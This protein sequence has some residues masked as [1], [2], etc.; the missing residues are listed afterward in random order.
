LD[1]DFVFC[2]HTDLQKMRQILVE[3]DFDILCGCTRQ[4]AQNT[5]T[6]P[7][8]IILKNK[9]IRLKSVNFKNKEF[10]E[11]DFGTNFFIAK[12]D[13][14]KMMGGWD[15]RLKLHTEHLDFF[16]TAQLCKL[17][18]G[19]CHIWIDHIKRNDSMAYKVHRAAGN[20]K[21]RR[22]LKNKWEIKD[23]TKPPRG[24]KIIQH[25]HGRI[26]NE[27]LVKLKK[28]F[29]KI[30][31]IEIDP[32]S[33][34]TRQCWF[35]APGIPKHRRENKICVRRS[36]HRNLLNEIKMLN[37]HYNNYLVYCGHGEPTMHP[38]LPRLLKDARTILPS[39]KIIV[40]TNGDLISP[41]LCQAFKKHADLITYDNYDDKTGRNMVKVCKEEGI[42][43]MVRCVDHV[44]HKRKYQSRA[45]NISTIKTKTL[46]TC[47]CPKP[48][49]E[50]FLSAEEK[51][52]VCCN[53]YGHDTEWG[54][55]IV[56]LFHNKK[57][58]KFLKDLETSRENLLPCKNC[59][60]RPSSKAYGNN[61]K[62]S[63]AK[64]PLLSTIKRLQPKEDN[65]GK[66]ARHYKN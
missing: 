45:G 29:D 42:L 30:K 8:R 3:N 21:Y 6:A 34:C 41:L 7:S 63:R 64:D 17:K 25:K 23:W 35:C 44:K 1:D 32:I 43:D 37:P 62:I 52:I 49:H 54:G 9:I 12:T 16:L 61:F 65:N 24:K 28:R 13:K 50:L 40:F 11:C 39:S 48:N 55:S 19:A 56:E 47:G 4:I 60:M 18:V 59:E 53:D 26:M 51:W 57:Y 36:F 66:L 10:I 5:A 33:Q 38:H 14:V 46:R 31:I 27:D 22:I 20:K 15:S 2:K 58:I